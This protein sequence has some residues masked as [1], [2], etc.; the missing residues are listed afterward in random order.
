MISVII[1]AH[2]EERTV[3]EVVRAAQGSPLVGEV[4]VVDDASY[5]KTSLHAREAGARVI[6]LKKNMGKGAALESG[7]EAARYDTLLFLDGDLSGITH[8]LIRELVTPVLKGECIMAIARRELPF[9]NLPPVLSGT[10]ALKKWLWHSVPEK[11]KSGYKVEIAL[12]YFGHKFGKVLHVPVVGL[13]H[14]IKENK[15]GPLYG[16]RKRVVM[17]ND[18]AVA[19]CMLYLFPALQKKIKLKLKPLRTKR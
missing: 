15:Y 17:M 12:N 8:E 16:F 11:C 19:G 7:I 6:T 13:Q 9:R 10:R 1:P 3:A 14:A 18:L 2:N 4:I 5:D